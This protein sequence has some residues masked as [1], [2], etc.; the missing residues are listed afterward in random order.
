MNTQYTPT[1]WSI[2]PLWAGVE[3]LVSAGGKQVACISEYAPADAEFI[4]RAVNN[5]ED[6]L[7]ACV[8]MVAGNMGQPRGVGVP[9]LDAMRAAIAKATGGEA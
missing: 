1:P 6:L 7:A 2:T 9:A 4:V 8:E 5:Y 3:Q